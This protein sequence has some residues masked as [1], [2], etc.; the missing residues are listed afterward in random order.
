MSHVRAIQLLSSDEVKSKYIAVIGINIDVGHG[1][2]QSDIDARLT[3][4]SP[5]A[6]FTWLWQ[7]EYDDDVR[8]YADIFSRCCSAHSIVHSLVCAALQGHTGYYLP[9]HLRGRIH[10]SRVEL[11]EKTCV[12]I[13]YNLDDVMRDNVYLERLTPEM[14]LKEVHHAIYSKKGNILSNVVIASS[15]KPIP[16]TQNSWLSRLL[17]CISCNQTTSSFSQKKKSQ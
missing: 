7:Y 17:S 3:A 4:L 8:R 14:N 15:R 5:Y 11:S 12:S 16:S 13:G 6:I 2:L 1:I 9:E 10:K